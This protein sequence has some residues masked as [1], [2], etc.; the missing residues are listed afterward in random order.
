M[1]KRIFSLFFGLGLGLLVGAFVIRRMDQASRAVRPDSLAAAA[2]RAAGG[3][4]TRLRAA[5]DETRRV[6]AEREAELRAQFQIP[7]LTDLAPGREAAA[8]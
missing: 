4:S 2:G 5:L 6:A 7:D 8:R 1:F 3:L